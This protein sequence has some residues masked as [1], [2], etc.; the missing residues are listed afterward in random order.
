MEELYAKLDEL[1]DVFNEDLIYRNEFLPHKYD[2]DEKLSE[3][4]LNKIIK[5]NKDLE[6]ASDIDHNDNRF[7]LDPNFLLA[8]DIENLLNQTFTDGKRRQLSG[9]F[10]YPYGGFCGWHTNNNHVGERSYL[11]WSADDKKSF[12]RYKDPKT[13]EIIT[14]WDKKGWQL[15]KFM[16][17]KAVPYWHCVGSKTNRISI[18]VRTL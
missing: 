11:T 3:E 9:F 12:F 18:G 10:W 8:F 14:D 15:R 4:N 16:V 6:I 2:I 7:L 13:D 17:S 5:N 1:L